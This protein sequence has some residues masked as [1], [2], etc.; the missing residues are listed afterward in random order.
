MISVEIFDHGQ[1]AAIPLKYLIEE[2]CCDQVCFQGCYQF[3]ECEQVQTQGGTCVRFSFNHSIDWDQT[4]IW[5]LSLCQRD[6]GSDTLLLGTLT[7]E[8]LI[9]MEFEW[10]I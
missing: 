6:A 7:A 8:L 2:E 9:M 4:D 3:L 10:G 5:F 1:T